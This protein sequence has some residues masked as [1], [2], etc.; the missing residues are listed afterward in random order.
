MVSHVSSPPPGRNPTRFYSAH[1][2]RRACYTQLSADPLGSPMASALL[3][4][5]RRHVSVAARV[6]IAGR[7]R[8]ECWR[9]RKSSS[10]QAEEANGQ[11]SGDSSRAPLLP[12]RPP[13]RKE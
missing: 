5:R 10:E 1:A 7:E 6:A 13:K 9:K 12:P 11:P 4:A 3:V 2:G 8:R